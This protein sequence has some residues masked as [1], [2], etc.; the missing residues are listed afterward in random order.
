MPLICKNAD[1]TPHWKPGERLNHLLEQR[2]DRVPS[3][4]LAVITEDTQLTFRELDNRANQ[5]ARYLLEQGLRPGDRVGVLFD[6]SV[7][8]YVGLLAVMKLGASYVPFDASFPTDRIAFILEDAGVKAIVSL[9][10]FRAKLAEL[11]VKRTFLNSAQQEISEKSSARLSADEGR[12][13]RDVPQLHPRRL[14]F[15]GRVRAS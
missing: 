13:A 14:R 10:R 1:N 3:D 15:T 12:A 8:C 4:H 11:A 6:K 5:T 7:H 2:C 9:S